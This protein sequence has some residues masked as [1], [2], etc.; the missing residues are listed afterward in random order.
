MKLWDALLA[1]LLF[2]L[3]FGVYSTS[4]VHH[5]MDSRWS[6]HLVK[7]IITEGDLDL[8]EYNQIIASMVSVPR[9]PNS[10]S[11]GMGFLVTF[12]TSL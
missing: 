10:S 7:S 6:I 9:H 8:D 1:P 5:S 2:L 11:Y 4:P 3:V 12:L